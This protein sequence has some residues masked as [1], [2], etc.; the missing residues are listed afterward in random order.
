MNARFGIDAATWSRLSPLLDQALDLPAA[1]RPA[2]LQALPTESG[3]LK[4][5]LAELLAAHEAGAA[6]G[7]STLPP[8]DGASQHQA[9]DTVGGY[10]LRRPLG[11]GGMGEVWEAVRV[12]GLI[13]RPVALKLP[14]AGS[15]RHALA[16]RMARERSILAALDH[17]HI[18]R[19][20]DAGIA[21]DG[22]PFL[23]LELVQG[24]R[25]DRWCDSRQLDMPAR[26]RLFLQVAHAVAHAH[27]QL[28][29][30][31]DL[32]PSN[33]LVDEGGQVKLL[34]FGIAKLLEAP[35]DESQALTQQGRRP[36]T[37][38]YASPEQI[39][40]AAVGT[41]SDIYSLG[42]VLC[43]LLS[44]QRPYRLRRGTRAEL[45]Q[46]VLE[47]EPARPSDLAH[48]PSRRALRGDLDTIVLMALK[49][50][51]AQRYA[52]VDAM[53]ADIARHLAGRPVLA[54][55]DSTWYRT[56]RFVARNAVAVAVG[57]A[58]CAALVAGA[59]IAVWQ[60]RE[61][62]AEA[63]RADE[64]KRFLAALFKEANPYLGGKA[65]SA[66]DL[67]KQADRKLGRFMVAQPAV[68]VEL[69]TMLGES[70]M[71]LGDLDA[72]EAAIDR[73]ATQARQLLP[74]HH[75]QAL[76]ARL[77]QVQVDRLRGRA[78]QARQA[79]DTLVPQLRRDDTLP[80]DLVVALQAQALL[81]IDVGDY[82]GASRVA[83]ESAQLALQR[84]GRQH[85]DTVGAAILLGLAHRYDKRFD[86]AREA[87]GQALSL[88]LEAYG[89]DGPHP[90][91]I[92]ARATYGRALADTGDLAGGIAQLQHAV[93]DARTL[94]G[95]NSHL[96]GVLLQNLVAYQ[97]D[98][99]ELAQ[100][101]RNSQE[102]LAILGAQVE[103]ESFTYA[104]T[105][106]AHGLALLAQYK[107]G[108]AA[109]V[110][111]EAVQILQRVLGPQHEATLTARSHLAL[112][113]ALNGELAQA[114]AGIEAVATQLAG[115]RVAPAVQARAAYVRALVLRRSA[116]PL[117]GALLEGLVE[118]TDMSP[119]LQRERMR[120]GAEL[121][122]L[123]AAQGD[124]A[125]AARRLGDALAAFA[126]LERQLTPPHAEA[127]VAMAKL[128]LA[129]GRAQEALPL[130][131]RAHAYWQAADAPGPWAEA[132]AAALAQCRAALRHTP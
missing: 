15:D 74:Q 51:P 83:V 3:A 103:K 50:D 20:Y 62:R 101:E 10:R 97:I 9:G 54:R 98:L 16:A 7:L 66:M 82:S 128:H 85:P 55:A 115:T 56:S 65:P 23:A 2:W 88:A 6:S 99:G 132:A 87:A 28:V 36:L 90:R 64:V 121:G 12:D 4:P 111:T 45:E 37:P 18:A 21:A 86:A 109:P 48:G 102:A 29:V 38:E 44:G 80:E 52:T 91:V 31:R 27:A 19:L 118:S 119:K 41:R 110:L 73:A 33:L 114:R 95:N 63:R 93:A 117:P 14:H 68:R 40:G 46:A 126:R 1:Q 112:A 92:E 34:D 107:A 123:L 72:A 71:M 89:A 120:A 57:A 32:K 84:L 108:R 125:G 30:H 129:Q 47:A 79:L 100:A 58:A 124:Q 24:E 104:G 105:L 8:L 113:Q 39:G 96:T 94:L 22:Q 116:Q 25:I 42:V 43:E 59:G 81:L 106:A 17:P 53:A 35:Q 70:L 131:E 76:H 122:A 60:A 127:L 11:A 26:L 130:L 78:A 5:L 13:D 69:G 75:P 49:K 77:L 67:V 61:A